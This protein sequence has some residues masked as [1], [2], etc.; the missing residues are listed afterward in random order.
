MSTFNDIFN[1]R[2]EL[3]WTVLN[4]ITGSFIVGSYLVD[5]VKANDVDIVVP[6]SSYQHNIDKLN[7]LEFSVS[8]RDDREYDRSDISCLVMTMRSKDRKVNLLIISDEYIACYKGA[9]EHCRLYP[10]MHSTREQR[11]DIYEQFEIRNRNLIK[12]LL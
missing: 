9:V 11:V 4:E 1:L 3:H 10:E 12:G 8:S 7:E 6:L 5:P 2:K